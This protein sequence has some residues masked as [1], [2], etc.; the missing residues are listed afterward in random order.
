M[1]KRGAGSGLGWLV[2][3]VIVIAVIPREIWLMLGVLAAMAGGVY[4]YL[5]WK[6]AKDQASAEAAARNEAIALGDQRRLRS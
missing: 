6:A 2:A 4:A 3:V 5:R 1:A